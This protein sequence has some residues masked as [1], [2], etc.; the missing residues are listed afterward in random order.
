MYR[1]SP[2]ALFRIFLAAHWMVSEM[3]CFYFTCPLVIATYLGST[4]V[5]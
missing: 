4:G 1:Q 3:L 5:I 2:L